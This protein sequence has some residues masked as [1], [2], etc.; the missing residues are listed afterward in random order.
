MLRIILVNFL[1]LYSISSNAAVENWYTL[2]GLGY[3]SNSYPKIIETNFSDIEKSSSSDR[4]SM[5]LDMFGFY[6]PT[7]NKA[8]LGFV[9]S[10][11]SDSADKAEGDSKVEYSITQVMYSCSGIKFFGKEIG[12][13]L[14]LRAD[15]GIVSLLETMEITGVGKHEGTA[16]GFGARA[17]IG[18]AIPVSEESRV[19]LGIDVSRSQ[20]KGDAFSSLRLMIAGLW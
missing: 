9:I 12:D 13:G 18:Y 20:I 16:S 7:N 15:A 4:F 8:M 19:L 2:W 17:G 1:L 10:G 5:G 3:A 14:F 11:T 6:V